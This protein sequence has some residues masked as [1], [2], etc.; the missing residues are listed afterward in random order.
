MSGRPKNPDWT[1]GSFAP[2][3]NYPVGALPWEGLP[4][5]VVWAGASSVGFTPKRNVPAQAINYLF[6]KAFSNHAD[7][8]SLISDV[9]DFVGQAEILNFP[10]KLDIGQDGNSA[11]YC[12]ATSGKR[13]RQWYVL[14]DEIVQPGGWDAGQTW[15]GDL[16][17]GAGAGEDPLVGDY[18]DGGAI[19][20]STNRRYCFQRDGN[21]GALSKVDVH[22][23]AIPSADSSA[24]KYSPVAALWC[25]AITEAA[26]PLRI[27]TSPDRTTWTSRT[28]PFGAVSTDGLLRMACNRATGRIVLANLPNGGGTSLLLGYSDNG[29]VTWTN[30]TALVIAAG[31]TYL[32]LAYNVGTGTWMLVVAKDYGT[33]VWTSATGITWTKVQT[34]TTSRVYSIAPFGN[35]WAGMAKQQATAKL[36]VVYS[37]D[38]GVTWK[39]AGVNP[40]SVAAGIFA[41]PD[42]LMIVCAS[43]TIYLGH[44][45][46]KADYGSL[47]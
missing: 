40:T 7:V 30:I 13:G 4:T 20:V 12:A 2:D 36:E 34:L 1:V 44:R 18:D 6:N 45:M 38:A 47:T 16:V 19:V 25:T 10:L 32:D 17:A 42:Q 11:F 29:G 41:G 5:K 43:D 28:P 27:R 8:Q 3:A 23:V 31:F 33:E 26:M 39:L 14:G 37:L 15:L 21:V 22:A 35:L 24:V 46:G 9:V